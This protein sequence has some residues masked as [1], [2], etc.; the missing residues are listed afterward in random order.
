MPAVNYKAL[1]TSSELRLFNNPEIT[2]EN[3][4]IIKQFLQ[5]YDVSD[6]R[7]EIFLRHIQFLLTSIKN[8][9]KEM[10]NRNYINKLFYDLRKELSINVY[11][12]VINVS[13]RL[14]RWLNDGDT[15]K[16]FKDI[17]N[18]AKKKLLRKLASEDMVTWENAIKL[19]SATN[20]IQFKA[21]IA[22]QLDGGFRPSEFID[23][24]VNDLSV[25]K[26]FIIVRVNKGKT[27]PR[28]VIL[29]RSVPFVI[30]WLQ[31]HPCKKRNVPLWVQEF[32]VKNGI[33]RYR[34]SSLVKRV[35]DIGN[36]AGIDKPMDFYNLRHSACVI[37]KLDNI[38][39][40]E[41][42]KR[43]GHSVKFYSETYGRMSPEDSINR[44]SK[45]YGLEIKKNLIQKTIL[46]PRCDFVNEPKAD[47]CE[48]CSAVINPKKAH[49]LNKEQTD[50]TKELKNVKEQLNNI[51]KFMNSLVNKD[52]GII[53]KLAKIATKDRK[54][55][56]KKSSK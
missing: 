55:I 46:C 24:N 35:R 16:G 6:A 29:W 14:V 18:V 26:E 5:V 44:L 41:A 9:K 17:K 27:G 39:E 28:S 30:R 47:Y 53:N 19:I 15:P 42:A 12:T 56:L 22:M 38:P 37:A 31:N 25:K 10:N 20:S 33:K 3:K 8:I 1:A 51:N 36:K 50:I 7:K 40:E 52:P 11:A 34:Y 4:K 2:T 21:V 43:F 48:K 54:K 13:K 45:I 32:A 23:L 49:E